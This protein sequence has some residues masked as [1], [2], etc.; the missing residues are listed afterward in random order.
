MEGVKKGQEQTKTRFDQFMNFLGNIEQE[1][2]NLAP[3]SR[4]ALGESSRI[5]APVEE[6]YGH[7]PREAYS[8][9]RERMIELE[10]E[11]EEQQKAL[12]MVKKLRVKEREELCKRVD[13]AKEEGQKTTEQVK[14]EMATRIEK[15][16]QMIEDL[17]QDKKNLSAKVEELIA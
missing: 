8:K 10:L 4:S 5:A 12:E 17:L 15:Q 2:S 14:S 6:S 1:F 16:V 3:S 9:V 11:K 7:N 13:L